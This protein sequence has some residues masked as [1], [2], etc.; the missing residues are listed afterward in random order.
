MA[1]KR[2]KVEC[3][4]LGTVRRDLLDFDRLQECSLTLSTSDV[5]C[6]LVCGVYLRGRS[7]QSPA[8]IHA[9]ESEHHIFI[10]LTDASVLCLP[11][12][13][14]VIDA[15]LDDVVQNCLP[16]YTAVI[17]P[18]FGRAIDGSQF[19]S[20]ALG[21]LNLGKTD[22]INAVVQ[23][24]AR[25][26]ELTGSLLLKQFPPRTLSASLS[27]LMKKLFNPQTFKAAVS[28]QEF[29]LTVQRLSEGRFSLKKQADVQGFLTWLLN[30]LYKEAKPLAK[31]FRGSLE[32]PATPFL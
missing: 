6:C 9:L 8:G 15:T 22:Y 1:R 5:Y 28:P 14:E 2:I 4:Y 30:R 18:V 12:N 7:L 10:S 17:Q 32:S 21:L 31:L 20:G 11:E 23:L 24:L 25:V 19:V 3:P 29:A 13:Y 16:S 26:P 27:N